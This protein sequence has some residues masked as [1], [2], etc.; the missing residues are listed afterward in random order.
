MANSLHDKAREAETKSPA[1]GGGCP[2]SA[3]MA[4]P[5]LDDIRFCE[6]DGEGEINQVKTL[7]RSGSAD[8]L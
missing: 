5:W 1:G 6:P 7:L 8:A 2:V 4:L 3:R